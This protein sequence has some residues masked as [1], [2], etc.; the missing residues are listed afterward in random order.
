[1]QKLWLVHANRDVAD[2]CVKQLKEDVL[3]GGRKVAENT[4]LGFKL[5]TIEFSVGLL[6]LPSGKKIKVKKAA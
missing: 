6:G 2:R 5:P 4:G 3:N 1:M